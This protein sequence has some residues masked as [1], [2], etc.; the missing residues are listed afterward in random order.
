MASNFKY[1]LYAAALLL[2][3]GLTLVLLLL[4]VKKPARV[5]SR[6]PTVESRPAMAETPIPPAP[7]AAE[8]PAEAP[9]PPDVVAAKDEL[10][11]EYSKQKGK[12]SDDVAKPID[13]DIGVIE[14]GAADLLAAIAHEPD[15][16]NLKLMLIETYRNEMKLLKKALHL[17][18]EDDD[19]GDAAVTPSN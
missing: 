4:L 8:E 3:T 17:S 10:R 14:R 11:A 1:V 2:I 16:E 19:T 6:P 7:P 5:E 18:S 9:A 13:E 15:N 12:I